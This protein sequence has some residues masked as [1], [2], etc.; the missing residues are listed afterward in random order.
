[1]CAVEAFRAALKLDPESP[2]ALDG[3]SRALM[4]NGDSASVI[5]LLA[6]VRLDEALALDL[7]LP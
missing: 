6:K 4:E 1:M 7:A 2:I 5:V 3:L